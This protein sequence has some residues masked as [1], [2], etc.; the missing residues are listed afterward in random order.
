MEDN[1][2]IF[3][4]RP[5]VKKLT[6]EKLSRTSSATSTVVY[7]VCPVPGCDY[8]VKTNEQP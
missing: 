7:R 2:C 8:K 3:H 4:K 5:L 1:K 6:N